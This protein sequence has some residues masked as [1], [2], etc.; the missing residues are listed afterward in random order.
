M[1]VP[2]L[3]SIGG[4]YR[5]RWQEEQV[6]I[7]LERLHE[8]SHFEVTCEIQ[9]NTTAAGSPSHLH[10]GSRLN[11][12]STESRRRLAKYLTEDVSPNNWTAMLEQASVMVLAEWRKGSPVIELSKHTLKDS[13][14]MRVA[15]IL[16]E[17]QATV[18]YGEGDTLKSFMGIFLAVLV[19]TGEKQAGLVPEPGNVLYLDYETDEDT[20]WERAGML[21]KG[22]ALEIPDGLFYRYM[23]QP[24]AADIQQINRIVL[25]K[26]IEFIVVDSAAPAV[27]EPESAA[28][29]TEYFRA[30]RSLRT[31][32]LTIAHVTKNT[33][34]AAPFGSIF[35]RNL[36]RANFMVTASRELEHVSIGLKHTKS[37]NGRRL[38]DLGFEFKFDGDLVSVNAVDVKDIPEL[39][40]GL[41]I[42]DQITS[43]LSHGALSLD[44]LCNVLPAL[45]RSR[46]STEL[47]RPN[48]DL[49]VNVRRGVW[50]LKARE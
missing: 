4:L 30:L 24:L 2:V 50:G 14:G 44:D 31:T 19:R 42:R 8:N 36:P 7:H 41:P 38:H 18:F 33:K 43:A 12:T 10:G 45:G 23:H 47:S 46:I 16:Q 48:Q 13:L 17:R 22:V 37:N 29:T 27:M 5:L 34:V 21:A 20:L 3:T 6:I 28:M 39:A 11:I 15:P 25:D 32:S 40:S 49:F 9:I 1:S 35:W 26:G